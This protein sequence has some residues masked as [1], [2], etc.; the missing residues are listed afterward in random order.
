MWL[1]VGVDGYT[2]DVARGRDACGWG[3][4]WRE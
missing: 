4:G 3:L 2:L 1:V